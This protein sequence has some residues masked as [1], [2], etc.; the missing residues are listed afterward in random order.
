MGAGTLYWLGEV[1]LAARITIG[2]AAGAAFVGLILGVLGAAVKVGEQRTLAWFVES[3]NAVLRGVPEILT[4]LFTYYGLQIAINKWAPLIGLAPFD[5]NPFAAGIAALGLTFGAYATPT[6]EGALR[7]VDR[8]QTDAALALGLRQRQAFRLV[9]LP[10]AWRLALPGL[11]N[12]W[13]VVLKAT[14][15]VSVISLDEVIHTTN[16]AVSVTKEPFF[17]FLFACVIYLVLTKVSMFGYTA[18]EARASRG[19]RDH[20]I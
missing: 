13:L 2:I 18:L 12:L 3:V 15:L 20:G 7:A 4:V 11:G 8:G 1:A 9:I 17:F 5:L 6:I 14:A 16:M 19:W 10:Q